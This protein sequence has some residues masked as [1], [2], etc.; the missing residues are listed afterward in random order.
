MSDKFTL[1]LVAK[2]S[3][4]CFQYA[5]KLGSKVLRLAITTFA[6]FLFTSSVDILYQSSRYALNVSIT[7]G[8]N[9][10]P[11]FS[12]REA[13]FSFVIINFNITLRT[14]VLS[15]EFCISIFFTHNAN[16]YIKC[17]Q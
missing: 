15:S 4:V 7:H 1:Y 9:T 17:K 2:V 5:L 13:V 14:N 3:A 6:I 12:S 10:L 16:I 11:E 8:M